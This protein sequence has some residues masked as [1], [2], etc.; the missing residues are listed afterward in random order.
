MHGVW[1]PGCISRISKLNSPSPFYHYYSTPLS[2]T[3]TELSTTTPSQ[4]ITQHH[5][6]TQHYHISTLSITKKPHQHHCDTTAS[7]YQSPVTHGHSSPAV[8]HLSPRGGITK[9]ILTYQ[10]L[11]A[12]ER[13]R[14]NKTDAGETDSR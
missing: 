7:A 11:G 10:S 9:Q 14:S 6:D 1:W 2:I 5:S 13:D 8:M 12:R 3:Y 4:T